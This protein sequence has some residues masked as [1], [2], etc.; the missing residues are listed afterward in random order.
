[1]RLAL[2][3]VVLKILLARKRRHDRDGVALCAL[4]FERPPRFHGQD[5][6]EAILRESAG[7][8]GG[9]GIEELL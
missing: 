7:V 4:V 8:S 2:F 3:V 5:V 9:G 6:G 1:V